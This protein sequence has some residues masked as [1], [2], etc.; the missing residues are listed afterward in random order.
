VSTVELYTPEKWPVEKL[1]EVESLHFAEIR[2]HAWL[3]T[4][5]CAGNINT[6]EKY[7][8]WIGDDTTYEYVDYNYGNWGSW[9][10]GTEYHPGL[11][12]VKFRWGVQPHQI[13]LFIFRGTANGDIVNANP[14]VTNGKINGLWLLA[15][16][17]NKYEHWNRNAGRPDIEA[18]GR[19][20]IDRHGQEDDEYGNPFWAYGI[21]KAYEE[22]P[23][24]TRPYKQ[25]PRVKDIRGDRGRHSPLERRKG[26][27]TNV[28]QT[29]FIRSFQD[30]FIGEPPTYWP[31]VLLSDKIS[32]YVMLDDNP[33]TSAQIGSSYRGAKFSTSFQDRI[34][35]LIEQ[36][37][38]YAV[39]VDDFWIKNWQYWCHFGVEMDPTYD[40]GCVNPHYNYAN[41][42]GNWV[43]GPAQGYYYKGDSVWHAN[44]FWRCIADHD[45]YEPGVAEGWEDYWVK[46]ILYQPNYIKNDPGYVQFSDYLHRC[47]SS[48]FEKVLKDIG[49]YD[50]YWDPNAAV[51][52]W[53]YQ[54]HYYHMMLEDSDP[55]V[56]H[57]EDAWKRYPLPRGCWRRVWRYTH[58]WNHARNQKARFGKEINIDG[59]MVSMMW[60]GELGNPPGY[61]QQLQ[62]WDVAWGTTYNMWWYQHVITQEL[63]DAMERPGGQEWLYTQYYTVVPVEDLFK[64][65]YRNNS[66]AENL[67]A[68]RH[69]PQDTCWKYVYNEGTGGYDWT[70]FPAFEIYADLVNDM[71]EALL[72]LKHRGQSTK[73]A[74]AEKN[75]TA[76]LSGY[77]SSLLAYAAGKNHCDDRDNT[78]AGSGLYGNVGYIGFVV[79]EITPDDWD[80]VGTIRHDFNMQKCWIEVTIDK[81]ADACFPASEVGQLV[82]DIAAGGNPEDESCAVGVPGVFSFKP[83]PNSPN[84]RAYVGVIP[85]ECTPVH[86]GAGS[87]PEDWT[88]QCK[89]EIVPAE[90]WMP[91]EMFDLPEPPPAQGIDYYMQ[92]NVVVETG[93]DTAIAWRLNFNGYDETVFEQDPYNFIQV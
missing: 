81:G 17:P 56:G 82:F 85:F 7:G 43:T 38:Q 60:P 89:F 1:D 64:A 21:W 46:E 76:E 36:E 62:W 48:A 91:D 14:P 13:D 4:H 80:T 6:T 70:E 3:I 69:D 57:L 10:P 51:P 66:A 86:T 87:D 72:Q 11:P 58:S 93:S 41:G 90:P 44:F 55:G 79:A 30:G 68:R 5:I 12:I 34:Q 45:S 2:R 47:N 15:P 54:K 9:N 35:H 16:D 31:H 25:V 67:I 65:A 59:K 52:W 32:E 78:Q 33:I 24:D 50:W 23:L 27:I 73:V 53:M 61:G 37:Y 49:E 83:P 26:D 88:I 74:V 75:I 20:I 22:L 40:A 84:L 28:L 71:R 18:D 92:S 19:W 63:Y 77:S 29:Q 42:R 39:K 8:K